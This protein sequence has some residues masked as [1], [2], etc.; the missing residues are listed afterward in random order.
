MDFSASSR[1]RNSRDSAPARAVSAAGQ[2][3]LKAAVQVGQSRNFSLRVLD[4]DTRLLEFLFQ[5]RDQVMKG[6]LVV[7]P[8]RHKDCSRSGK[9]A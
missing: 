2:H 4:R 6:L 9:V 3:G 5:T 7:V 8:L 1:T